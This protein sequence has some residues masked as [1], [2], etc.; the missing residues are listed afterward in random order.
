[1]KKTTLIKYLLLIF[2]ISI[3]FFDN[4][5][6]FA[7]ED[8]DNYSDL[9][10]QYLQL[11]DEEKEKI[12]VI[13]EKYTTSLKKVNNNKSFKRS[14]RNLSV[15]PNRYN[16]AEHYNIKVKNQGQEGNCWAFASLETLETYLQ[17]HGY[18]TFD[19]SE[20]HLNYI[21]SNLFSETDATRKINAAGNYNELE[22]YLN[23]KLGPVSEDQFPYYEDESILKNKK[24]TQDEIDNLLNIT[25]LAYVGEFITF[26][27]V[28][29]KDKDENLS[30]KELTEYR[31][32]I[33]KHIMENGAI[34][35][36]I[37]AP[38]YY[39]NEFYNPNTYAAYFPNTTDSRFQAHS[40]AVA[41]IGWDDN[42]S[43]DN[44]I[45]GNKPKHDGAY[46][47]LNSWGSSFGDCGLYYISYDDAYVEMDL[48]GIKEAATDTSNL[49]NTTTFSVNDN[50]LYNAL[51][52]VLGRK[53]INSNDETLSITMLNGTINEIQ[54]LDLIGY[55]IS[56][57]SGIENLT[58]LTSLNLSNNNI[59]S[60]T[61]LLSLHKLDTINLSNNQIKTIP[62]E[63]YNSELSILS[64]SYNPIN[65]FSGIT[66]IKSISTLNLEGTN[67][68]ENDLQYLK[69]K[70][71]INLNLSKT[72][73][74]DY[75]VLKTLNDKLEPDGIS[76]TG[77]QQLNISYN[78]NVNYT[79]IPN[80]SFL[81]ISNTSVDENKFKQIPDISKLNALDISYTHIKN[82]DIL[83][84]IPLRAAYISGNKDLQNI[85]VLK[86]TGLIIYK[87][88]GLKDT[89]IFKDFYA[90]QLN[91]ASNEI[92]NYDSL[93][94]NEYLRFLDLSNNKLTMIPYKEN[95]RITADE[96]KIKPTM[97][98]LEEIDS[99]KNQNY[100]EDLYVDPN[101]ENMFTDIIKN[102]NDFQ[103]NGIRF[104]ITNATMD[105]KN[106]TFNI[107]DYDKDVIIKIE[108]GIYEGST[109]TYK[110]INQNANMLYL[111]IDRNNLRTRYIEGET[112][113]KN[114]LK[115]YAY[116]DTNSRKEITD[117]SITGLENLHVGVNTI[118]VEKD[119]FSDVIDI[120]I[121]PNNDIITLKFENTDIYKATLKKIRQI[122]E[123]RQEYA[124]LYNLIDVLINNNN[125]DKTINIL[126]SDLSFIN[127]IEIESDELTSFEDIKQLK[128]LTGIY[129]NGKKFEDLSSLLYIKE[130][131]DA[132]VD[133]MPYERFLGIEIKNNEKLVKID[134]DIFRMIVLE[135][136][137]ITNLNNLTNLGSIS[138][139]GNTIPNINDIL[140]NL[141]MISID[142][143]SKIDELE[144]DENNNI[145]L[146][147]L[148]KKFKDK[149][150][151][152]EVNICDQ[153]RDLQY[154]NPYNK[155][156]IEILDNGENLLL[157]YDDI[158]G[159]DFE[160]TNQFIE[161]KITDVN[162]LYVK[163]DFNFKL[164]YETN[165]KSEPIDDNETNSNTTKENDQ[166]KE[167]NEINNNI[168]TK[169]EREKKVHNNNINPTTGDH[170]ILWIILIIVS[171]LGIVVVVIFRKN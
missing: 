66:N 146:P 163:F 132:Q 34:Y 77:L 89:S 16:L 29:K 147:N 97:S 38:T 125:D 3:V 135:N 51:K 78:E 129:L 12:E 8:V 143:N 81:N 140:D 2:T 88:A 58:N 17:I 54:F 158:K 71:I 171:I 139:K 33:K 69:N 134:Y 115:V 170:I 27:S 141:Y 137:K 73:I 9:Y 127:Y 100:V 111:S 93:L 11:S 45:E 142:V 57:L 155:K 166:I 44:F 95:I 105:F 156:P 74:K 102:L 55:N 86:Y 82:L 56:D 167:S 109:I 46:I 25:P 121:I 14:L 168:E 53:I 39:Q 126:K 161:I 123:E 48:H 117:Y 119:G 50:N 98:Y 43:K 59:S 165:N 72:N 4:N 42:F 133:L 91:L 52:D 6:S 131:L 92:E 164:N 120:T 61:P 151:K 19:F 65:N 64:L 110:L 83:T 130:I 67:I 118:S 153:I 144:K 113:D 157:K 7:L 136:T 103:N 90:S 114:T 62:V 104:T 75:T 70:K 31:N 122:E 10:K 106:N 87:D 145:I 152:F 60:I 162:S 101:K 18:G 150:L 15:L 80:V 37:T 23:K 13:P 1:M 5:N 36:L 35:T 21:E 148:L 154:L 108:N 40:H 85:D 116:Y 30:E 169:D 32:N 22:E 138:Y 79:T 112:F 128:G 68:K 124:Y 41:I 160:G 159:I 107:N 24:Y 96:N 76:D 20:N 84:G 26:P 63:L 47:A 49:V 28:S 149:G 94:E 99:A